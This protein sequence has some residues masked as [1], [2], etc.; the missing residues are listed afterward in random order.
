MTNPWKDDS[1]QVEKFNVSVHEGV[2][3]ILIGL[4]DVETA[5][6]FLW[7]NESDQ[8]NMAA[9]ALAAFAKFAND[10]G[11]YGDEARKALAANLSAA[12]MPIIQQVAHSDAINELG[13]EIY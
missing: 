8:T 5:A 4:A 9:L 1:A 3:H 7:E 10:Y 13:Y 11:N 2:E 12:Y 6:K